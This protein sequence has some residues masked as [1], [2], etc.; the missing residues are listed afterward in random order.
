MSE[1]NLPLPPELARLST[2]IDSRIEC[3]AGPSSELRST[4]LYAAK[5]TFDWGKTNISGTFVESFDDPLTSPR[6]RKVFEASSTD[7]VGHAH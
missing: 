5:H 6:D 3:L 7:T 2:F 4:A 1:R